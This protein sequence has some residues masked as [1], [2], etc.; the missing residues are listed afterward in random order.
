MYINQYNVKPVAEY[1]EI[2]VIEA[3]IC[4]RLK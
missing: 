2:L 4:D 1:K 3:E